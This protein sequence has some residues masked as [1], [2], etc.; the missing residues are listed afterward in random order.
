MTRFATP[1]FLAA[2]LA[3]RWNQ[4][5]PGSRG[6]GGDRPYAGRQG[7]DPVEPVTSTDRLSRRVPAHRAGPVGF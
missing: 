1:L 2:L 4:S 6:E 3:M 7:H 5:A